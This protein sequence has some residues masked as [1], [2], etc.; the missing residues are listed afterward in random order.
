MAIKDFSPVV[1]KIISKSYK[2]GSQNFMVRLDSKGIRGWEGRYY[3]VNEGVMIL[4]GLVIFNALNDEKNPNPYSWNPIYNDRIKGKAGLGILISSS[5]TGYSEIYPFDASNVTDFKNF[6]GI[7]NRS[8]KYLSSKSVNHWREIFEETFTPNDLESL[9]EQYNE[10][11]KVLCKK[12]KP[13]SGDP[14]KTNFDKK[15]WI[16]KGYPCAY[17]YGF[18]WKG[19]KATPMANDEALK[20]FGHTF[21]SKYEKLNDKWHL[22]LQDYSGSDM[23]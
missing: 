10:R 18:A 20:K 1:K 13:Y 9:L 22:V 11:A 15:T 12:V 16:E 2:P 17:R 19:A 5:Q 14:I 21:E 6:K 23:W 3:S 4:K 7:A 8:E